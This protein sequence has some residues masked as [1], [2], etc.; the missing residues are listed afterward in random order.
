MYTLTAIA[1]I[2]VTV[3]RACAVGLGTGRVFVQEIVSCVRRCMIVVRRAVVVKLIMMMVVH[4]WAM[5]ELYC[6]K[7]ILYSFFFCFTNNFICTCTAMRDVREQT[8]R[9]WDAAP[10]TAEST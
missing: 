5:T 8:S 6:T 10:E 9:H 2:T 1:G 4:R 7:N 3:Q